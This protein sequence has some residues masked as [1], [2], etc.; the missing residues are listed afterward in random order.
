MSQ[1]GKYL[2]A[3]IRAP[4]PESLT[5]GYGLR[6]QPQ[7]LIE[8]RG[9]VAIASGVDLEEFGEEG[10]RHN[11]ENLPWLEEVARVHHQVVQ[12]VFTAAP[13]APLRLATICLDAEAVRARLDALHDQIDAVLGRISGSAEWGV[14]MYLRIP[15]PAAASVQ[16]PSTPPAEQ[17]GRT[18]AAYLQ[19]K[20]NEANK[21]RV[22]EEYA[23][24]AARSVHTELSAVAVASRLLRPQDPKLSGHPDKLVLNAAY[25]V[26]S[27]R[28]QE[29]VTR[30]EEVLA[31][32]DQYELVRFGPWP[33]YSFA[34]LDDA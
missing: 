17:A 32:Q 30:S 12:F 27:D 4:A 34:G 19:R 2:Y 26:R 15:T 9:L 23:E 7:E 22:G 10:L 31:G 5:T 29:F 20:R 16:Q 13:A 28:E 24:E 6:G 18:G 21:R 14:K 3:V 25:L 1:T 11:L 33:P 8:H